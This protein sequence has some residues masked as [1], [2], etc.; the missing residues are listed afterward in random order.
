M[1]TDPDLLLQWRQ[2]HGFVWV[3]ADQYAVA[4]TRL[5]PEIARQDT[6][7]DALRAS[8]RGDQ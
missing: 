5:D 7:I 1:A 3:T 6:H 8:L 2:E 4:V